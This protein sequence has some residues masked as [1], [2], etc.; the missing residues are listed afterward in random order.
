M[1]RQYGRTRSGG[2]VVN[3]RKYAN[4]MRKKYLKKAIRRSRNPRGYL[5][6]IRKLPELAIVNSASGA[7]NLVDPTTTCMQVNVLGLTTGA[8]TTLYDVAFSMRFRLDQLLQSSDIT[9]L[10]DKYKIKSAYVKVFYNNTQATSTYSP[11]LNQA[12]GMPTL[13]YITD[14]DDAILPGTLDRLRERMGVKY[15]TF[16]SGSSYI[17]IKVNPRCT[18]EVFATGTVSGYEQ[19]S[20]PIWLDS[21]SDD[22]EHYGIKGVICGVPLED[23]SQLLS[24]FKFDVAVTVE[25][26]DFQ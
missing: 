3:R 14:H 1:V 21:A 20:R 19:V 23:P 8:P 12:G 5:K 2:I 7:V 11:A 26:A 9:N 16:K 6:I 24:L 17:G 25:A 13:Q 15:K 4:Y 10:A 22:V 18:R